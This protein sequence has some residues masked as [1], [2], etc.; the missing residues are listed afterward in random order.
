MC[1][2]LT[3]HARI[4]DTRI[5][6]LMQPC[7]HFWSFFNCRNLR[8]FGEDQMDPTSAV[9]GPKPI[10]RTGSTEV[11]PSRRASWRPNHWTALETVVKPQSQPAN[12]RPRSR[13]RKSSR[14]PPR[15]AETRLIDFEKAA[16]QSKLDSLFIRVADEQKY[17]SEQLNYR[18]LRTRKDCEHRR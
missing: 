1:S 4:P 9:G 8:S 6:Q 3:P 5:P 14:A 17:L 11:Q 15:T 12:S 10:L 7:T 13:G 16:P 18:N 2:E